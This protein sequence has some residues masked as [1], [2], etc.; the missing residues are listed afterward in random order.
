[1]LLSCLRETSKSRGSWWRHQMVTFSLC[2]GIHRWPVISPNERQSRWA[3]TYSLICAWINR[4][5]NN[6]D[7][8]DLRHHRGDYD[9]I[10]M[11]IWASIRLWSVQGNQYC[12]VCYD[13]VFRGWKLLRKTK[14]ARAVIL[15][16]IT[17]TK[18][19]IF[20]INQYCNLV[21]NS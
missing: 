17:K 21:T 16:I 10:A 19:H 9:V 18:T 5:V 4:W 7:A 2:A 12:D 1:M 14:K 11:T 15:V 6:R 8:G 13:I 3:L 20:P